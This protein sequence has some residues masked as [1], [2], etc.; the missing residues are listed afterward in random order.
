MQA[1]THVPKILK[2]LAELLQRETN[3][4]VDS[5]KAGRFVITYVLAVIRSLKS[6]LSVGKRRPRM[7]LWL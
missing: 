4:Y 5:T 1:T 3:R 7:V 2:K 6:S